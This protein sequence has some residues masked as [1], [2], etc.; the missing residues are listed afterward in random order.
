MS[1]LG[2]LLEVKTFTDVYW[3]VPHVFPLSTNDM[4]LRQRDQQWQIKVPTKRA[5]RQKS[6]VVD[7]YDEL[8]GVESIQKHLQNTAKV[9]LS[10]SSLEFPTN[11]ELT[12]FAKITTHRSSFTLPLTSKN[13]LYDIRVDFDD[14]SGYLIGECEIIL[15]SHNESEMNS[16]HNLLMEFCTLHKLD[17]STSI[18]GKVLEYIYN[19][20][21]SHYQAL[22]S[23]GL[24]QSKL[25]Q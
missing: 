9:E 11:F 20:S 12:P 23:A 24:L 4:W 1:R 14:A 2:T 13:T 10:D 8:Y 22:E 18:R 17:T 16:A 15:D 19:H 21:P 7:V 6:S 25:V 5:T 3:D